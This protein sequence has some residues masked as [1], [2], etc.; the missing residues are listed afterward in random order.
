VAGELVRWAATIHEATEREVRTDKQGRFRLVDVPDQEGFVQVIADQLA[1]CFSRVTEGESEIAVALEAGRTAQGIVLSR[2]RQPLAGA[3]VV[4]VLSSPDP[5]LCKPLRLPEREAF[6]DAEGRFKLSGLPPWNVRFD[7]LRE[8]F[9][10]LTDLE[11]GQG[12]AHNEIHMTA[13]GAIR[14]IVLDPQGKPVRDF[15]IRI[16]IP[17]SL[18]PDEQAGGYYAGY[19]WYGVS[20]TADDGTFVVSDM[21]VGNWLRVQAIARG[22]GQAIHDRVRASPLDQLPP[23]D[24][25]TLRLT[26]PHQL[27]VHVVTEN[28]QQ[29]LAGA[30]I[31]LMDDQPRLDDQRFNWGS[32]NR[33]GLRGWTD[34]QGWCKF[35]ELVF[36]EATLVVEHEGYERKRFGWR[37]QEE[38]FEVSLA[39]EAVIQGVIRRDGLPLAQCQVS[40]A[41]TSGDR[42]FLVTGSKGTFSFNQ[43]PAGDYSL[44]FLNEKRGLQ[45]QQTVKLKAGETRDLALDV[46]DPEADKPQ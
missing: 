34:Q 14:G 21:P 11:L 27:L 28:G 6:T 26:A 37:Q 32:D 7:F 16:Q 2:S 45:R 36:G 9:A 30:R 8:G 24:Q 5:A 3:R 33:M 43:L 35:Q 29:P 12:Q 20:F 25:L 40:L 39:P 42:Y 31:T 41:S 38:G 4:P 44:E 13:G 15:R 18:Q 19:G 10:A 1:P 23:A 46:T 22:H 17:R